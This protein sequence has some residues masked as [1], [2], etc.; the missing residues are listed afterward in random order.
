MP[1]D[2]IPTPSTGVKAS[3][4]VPLETFMKHACAVLESNGH[5]I[6]TPSAYRAWHETLSRLQDSQSSELEIPDSVRNLTWRGS[7]SYVKSKEVV[8]AFRSLVSRMII[9]APHGLE[10]KF[11]RWS[12]E[13]W[14]GEDRPSLQKT[15]NELEGMPE[16]YQKAVEELARGLACRVGSVRGLGMGMFAEVELTPVPL[17]KTDLPLP[18][19]PVD[20]TPEPKPGELY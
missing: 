1:Q 3:R 6:L 5:P 12:E 2:T 14:P 19:V 20:A 7:D 11:A 13:E 17:R 18:P 10:Y 16:A 8:Q 9:F 4:E 15:L